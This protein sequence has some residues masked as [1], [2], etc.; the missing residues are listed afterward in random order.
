MD[1]A[2]IRAI[3]NRNEPL[4]TWVDERN[5]R[6]LAEVIAEP[7]I[8]FNIRRWTIRRFHGLDRRGVDDAQALV[9]ALIVA[10]ADENP[11][12]RRAAAEELYLAPDWW[13]VREAAPPLRRLLADPDDHVRLDAAIALSGMGDQAAKAP[14]LELAD[15]ANDHTRPTVIAALARLHTPEGEAA[16]CRYL[17]DR[18]HSEWAAGWLAEMGTKASIRPL[19][20]ARRWHPFARDDYTAAISEIERRTAQ[21][22]T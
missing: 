7:R 15:T 20:R 16:M 17:K 8:K 21:Q 1:A 4:R 2:T 14:L 10:L 11:W 22:T 9:A 3:N 18:K 13:D 12:V 6:R 19:K 5:V